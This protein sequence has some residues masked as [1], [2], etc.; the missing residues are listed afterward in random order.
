MH[1]LPF[2]LFSWAHKP[3]IHGVHL[4]GTIDLMMGF[5]GGKQAFLLQEPFKLS[6]RLSNWWKD[7]N[8]GLFDNVTVWNIDVAAQ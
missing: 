1:A 3:D 8:Y 2:R 4:F 7:Y 5:I 6:L